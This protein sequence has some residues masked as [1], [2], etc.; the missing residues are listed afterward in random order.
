MPAIITNTPDLIKTVCSPFGFCS[1]CG[2]IF[3]M[4]VESDVGIA[5]GVLK[6]EA[7]LA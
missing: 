4:C 2:A 5:T 6:E 1:E 3:R 7:L